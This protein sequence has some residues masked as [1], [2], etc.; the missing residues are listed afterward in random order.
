MVNLTDEKKSS[1]TQI[2][3]IHIEKMNDKH[4]S[5]YHLYRKLL[6]PNDKTKKYQ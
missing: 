5:D 6:Q 2:Q 3:T 1:F 4:N